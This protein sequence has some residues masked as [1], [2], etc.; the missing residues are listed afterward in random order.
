MARSNQADLVR[1]LSCGNVMLSL[2]GCDRSKSA[3]PYR[4][5][6]AAQIVASWSVINVSRSNM[7]GMCL[8]DVFLSRSSG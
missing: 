3:V 8:V 4:L 1:R 5:H 2:P 6:A 7:L